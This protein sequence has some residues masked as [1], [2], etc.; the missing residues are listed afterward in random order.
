MG[1]IP[2]DIFE[3]MFACRGPSNAVRAGAYH[4]AAAMDPGPT[5]RPTRRIVGLAGLLA[6]LRNL[7]MLGPPGVADALHHFTADDGQ[8]IPVKVLGH[9]EAIVLVHGLGCSHRHW[10]PVARRLARRARVLAWDARCHGGS[11]AQ[12]GSTVTLQRLA[13]DLQQLLDHFGLDRVVLVGHSMGALTVMQYLRDHGSGRVAA[14]GLVDQSPRIVTDASWRLGLF[15]G[16]SH[17]ML[18]GLI[19]SARSDL[20]ELVMREL[21]A[22]AG[23]WLRRRTGARATLAAM[24]RRWLGR[25]DANPLLDLAESLGSADFRALLPTLDR[26][27]WVVL[28][29][30]S[31]HYA[32]VPLEGYYRSAIRHATVSVFERSGHSPHVAE[33]ERFARELLQFLA[34]HA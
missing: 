22:L 21:E 2:I 15:G 7:G 11:A 8:R 12:P 17:A 29:G 20:A 18:Q 1:C 23:E 28:G 9:G 33:P 32:G 14:V 6:A 3:T 19:A 5:R 27:V 26:P 13:A 25:F 16:C 10:L 34:D 24:L 4:A 30:R 31:A